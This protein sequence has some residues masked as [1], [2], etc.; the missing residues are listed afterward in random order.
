MRRA[1][2][3]P[4][5]DAGPRARATPAAAGQRASM[6]GHTSRRRYARSKRGSRFIGSSAASTASV[7]PSRCR[8]P[9][10]MS[11][12]GRKCQ[13][14]A[15]GRHTGIADRPLSPAPRSSC[16]SKVSAWSSAW[17]AVSRH[18][19]GLHDAGEGAIARH[20]RRGL[21]RRTA[22]DIHLD[23]HHLEWHLE[24]AAERRGRIAHGVR[25]R[26]QAVIDVHGAQWQRPPARAAR[27]RG[28]AERSRATPGG[29]KNP[30]RR[31]S[32]RADRSRPAVS[33]PRAR[34]TAVPR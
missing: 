11:R 7:L 2:P 25:C 12:S 31:S 4:R 15:N 16:S 34:P 1:R 30:G 29:K 28:R 8:S 3:A 22:L 26:L 9:G 5:Q 20:A 23:P 33:R 18:S 10:A 14:C 21:D 17:C 13:P 32:R 19:P 27:A 24:P 6:R